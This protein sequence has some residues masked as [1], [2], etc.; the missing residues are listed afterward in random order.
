MQQ[1]INKIK[2]KYI[3]KSG[4]QACNNTSPISQMF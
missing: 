1:Q 2:D 4:I 3:E